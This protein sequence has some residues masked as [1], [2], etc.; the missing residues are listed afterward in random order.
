MSGNLVKPRPTLALERALLLQGQ[1]NIA[2]AD[3]VGVGA[4]A[5]PLVAAA[6]ILPLPEPGPDLEAQLRLL[7]YAILDVRDSKQIRRRDQPRLDAM[8]HELAGPNIGVGRIDVGDLA[9]I[10]NQ[11]EASRLATIRA[12]TALPSQPGFVL[13]DG[14]L[15]LGDA[16]FPHTNVRKIANGTPSLSIAA[17]SIIATVVFRQIMNDYAEMFPEYGF[18]RHAGYPSPAH[19][20]ALETYGPSPVHHRHNRLIQALLEK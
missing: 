3:E 18:D 8:L 9:V 11:T 4:I 12:V 14:K 5:G 13:L 20:A 2:G 6:I 17:A 15:Q 7:E 16:G 10:A 19:L 1:R